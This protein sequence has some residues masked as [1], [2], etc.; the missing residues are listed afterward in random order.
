MDLTDRQWE[1]GR[2]EREL[3]ARVGT[4]WP[5]TKHYNTTERTS[6]IRINMPQ[7]ETVGTPAPSFRQFAEHVTHAYGVLALNCLASFLITLAC[8]KVSS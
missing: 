6:A 5:E 7:F 4:L 2:R 3:A 8:G 1:S